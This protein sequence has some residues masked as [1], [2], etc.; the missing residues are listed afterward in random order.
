MLENEKLDLLNDLK[1]LPR[2]AALRRINELVKRTRS[3]KVHAYILHYLRKQLPFSNWGKKD[4]QT[5]LIQRLDKE[6]LDCARR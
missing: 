3:V 4:K 5:L 1:A 6:F 2:N